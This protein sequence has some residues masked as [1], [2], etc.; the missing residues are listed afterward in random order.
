MLT[1]GLQTAFDE[2]MR[3]LGAA[4]LVHASINP[5]AA[6]GKTVYSLSMP[7][8][9]PVQ[10]KL[11][12]VLSEGEQ[13]VVALA[14]FLAEARIAPTKVGLII[15]DPVSSLDHRW[16]EKIAERL[17]AL[18]RDRQIIVFT[19]SIA[20][21]IEAERF[22]TELGTSLT[23]LFIAKTA[24]GAGHCGPDAEPWEKLNIKTRV[25]AF[26][27]EANRL[28]AAFTSSPTG[29]EY[30]RGAAQ[31]CGDL[32]SAWERAVEEC[33][34]NTAVERFGYA[35]STGRLRRAVCTDATFKSVY[36]AMTRLSAITA[37]HDKARGAFASCPTPDDLEQ[38][39][40]NLEAFVAYQKAEADKAEAARKPLEDPPV[41]ST[42]GAPVAA[43][44]GSN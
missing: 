22:A 2:E 35:V 14:Y 12:G 26:K 28:R 19:H 3:L 44:S 16:A 30:A 34:F 32:R 18:A 11:S 8:S 27:D 38:Y 23:K 20:F 21:L 39:I 40:K 4:G 10:W 7:G 1:G 37:A 9:A 41:A 6:K 31:L 42:K 5:K 25:K 24:N 15:D 43:I 29:R 13:R 36:D 33:V 17:A